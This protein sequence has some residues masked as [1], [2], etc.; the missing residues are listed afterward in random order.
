MINLPGYQASRLTYHR[1]GLQSDVGIRFDKER[2]QEVKDAIEAEMKAIEQEV[3]P[4]LPPRE[5]K[6]AERKEYTIP[7]RPF[8]KD[9]TLSA[10]MEKWVAKHG[11]R[12]LVRT[13]DGKLFI[14]W[15]DGEEWPIEGSKELPGSKP[16]TLGNQ[17]DIK[18]YLLDEGWKPTL[19]NYKKDD[20]GKP[21]RDESGK[22]IKTSPKMQENGKLCPNLEAMNGDLVKPIVKW[23]SLRNRHAV[24]SGWMDNP[25]LEYDGRLPGGSSGFA[26]THR[27]KHSVIANL[28]KAEESVTYGREMRSVFVPRPGHGFVGYDAS[29]L[30][31]RVAGHYTHK[32]DGGAYAEE[33]LNGD[34]HSKNAW[35]FYTEELLALGLDPTTPGLK[36]DPTF[37]PFRN[38]SKNGYYL[39]LYGGQAPRLAA[40]LGLPPSRGEIAYEAF[41]EAPVNQALKTLRDNVTRFWETKGEKKFI[42]AIDGRILR[43]RAKHALLNTLFQSCGAIVMDISHL[44]LEK[45]IGGGIQYDETGSPMMVYKGFRVYRVLYY[46]DEYLWEVPEP[47]AEEFAEMATRSITKAGE[48]LNLNVPL[49]GGYKISPNNYAEVH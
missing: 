18:N 30:E 12:V 29:G 4:K 37:I 32:Y 2:A 7:A 46:H 5:L 21:I 36:D 16:M 13:R 14:E 19:W 8:K 23:L 15:I 31:G 48:Y 20:R 34:I 6:A 41:W 22:L 1:M 26:M 10:V 40:T 3:E 9:G 33:L 43:T 42:K 28:P 44:F 45:M 24:L 25:R 17:E 27:Q 35:A 11:V 47:I 49:T 38:K 39:L